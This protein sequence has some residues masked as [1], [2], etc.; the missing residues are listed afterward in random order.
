MATPTESLGNSKAGTGPYIVQRGD[1]IASI[2]FA[3]GFFPDTVWKHAGNAS[4]RETRK[5][6]DV[7]LEGDR[8]TLPI[9]EEKTETKP[10]GQRH[11]FRRKGV[12]RW[13]RVRFWS[14]EE[15]PLSH[16]PVRIDVD[17]R[18]G[19]GKTDEDGWFK[20]AISPDARLAKLILDDSY[21]YEL[22]LGH[23]SPIDTVFGIQDRLQDLGFYDGPIDGNQSQELKDA[24]TKFQL[25]QNLET[26]GQV[27]AATQDE[28]K[29]LVSC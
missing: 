18:L 15:E 10:S 29:K 6:P 14:G 20:Y 8:V 25:C 21:S 17:G 3:Y 1:C 26:S 4:L 24:L 11:R 19:S 23:L 22:R 28:L 27:D 5:D 13:L 7:L 9:K 16:R 12:P 2:A